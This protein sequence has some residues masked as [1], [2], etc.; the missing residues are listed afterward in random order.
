MATRRIAL[1]ESEVRLGE[2]RVIQNFAAQAT[3]EDPTSPLASGLDLVVNQEL[4]DN[5]PAQMQQK[6][7][8]TP[9]QEYYSDPSVYVHCM[10]AQHQV[11]YSNLVGNSS[12]LTESAKEVRSIP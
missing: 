5:E 9:W 1:E 10:Q 11:S 3:L 8:A 7:S 12:G 6:S 4:G 2:H